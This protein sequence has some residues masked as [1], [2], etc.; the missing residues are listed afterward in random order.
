M[1]ARYARKVA[2]GAIIAVAAATGLGAGS[3]ASAKFRIPEEP[4]V[5]IGTHE[6]PQPVVAPGV[7]RVVVSL[8]YDGRCGR[9]VFAFRR[10]NR[11]SIPFC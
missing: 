7:A 8:G 10:G 3:A 6:T 2:L 1:K 9:E 11:E 4:E 5:T